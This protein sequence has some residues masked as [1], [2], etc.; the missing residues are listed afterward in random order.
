M[1][2][3]TVSQIFP[4]ENIFVT[5][6]SPEKAYYYKNFGKAELVV[7]GEKGSFVIGNNN[8]STEYKIF[9]KVNSGWKLGNSINTKQIIRQ[10]TDTATI[11][12]YNY[13]NTNDYYIAV[14]NI[15]GEQINITDNC[16]SKF[17]YL[18]KALKNQNTSFYTYY[19]YIKNFNENYTV[20]INN[21]SIKIHNN[22]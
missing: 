12:V 16:G 9:P 5:F 11:Y 13:T 8:D 15:N 19:A 14:S 17:Q 1:C 22:W 18:K 3:I 21:K 4:V 10:I 7:N 20:I 2:I 6:S